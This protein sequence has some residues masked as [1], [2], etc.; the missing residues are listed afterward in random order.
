MDLQQEENVLDLGS[1]ICG[2]A[3]YM[4]EKFGLR[5]RGLEISQL[6]ATLGQERIDKTGLNDH[7][8]VTVA[9]MCSVDLPQ[10][11]FDAVYSRDTFLHINRVAEM[12]RTI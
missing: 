1:G 3:I 10:D 12:I 4:A 5:V 2:S 7:I 8:T 9:N 11:T 6:C